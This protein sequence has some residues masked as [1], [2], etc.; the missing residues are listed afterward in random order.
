MVAVDE[1]NP[2]KWYY[3]CVCGCLNRRRQPVEHEPEDNEVSQATMIEEPLITQ[4]LFKKNSLECACALE[5]EKQTENKNK[6]RY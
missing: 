5:I 3:P 6:K 4:Q 1:D 2:L